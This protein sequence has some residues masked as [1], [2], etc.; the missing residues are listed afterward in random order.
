M[1]L[2]GVAGSFDEDGDFAKRTTNLKHGLGSWIW[3]TNVYPRQTCRFWRTFEV[4]GGSPVVRALL[5]VTADNGYL[6][7]LDGRE[8]GKGSNWKTVAEYD[9][10]WRLEPGRHILAVEA[11]ND[12]DTGGPNIAGVILGLR[13]AFADGRVLELGTDSSWRVPPETERDW[14]KRRQAAPHWPAAT[15]LAPWGGKKEW[16]VPLLIAHEPPV[17]PAAVHFWQQGWFQVTMLSVCGVAVAVCLR[18]MAQMTLQTRA[19]RLLQLERARIARDIHDELGAGLTRLVL[20][21]EVTQSE[22]PPDSPVRAQ[23]SQLCERTR[24]L[25]QVMDEVVWAVN[26]RRDTLQDFATYVCKYAGTFLAPTPIRCRLDVE[27]ELPSVGFDLPM[28]RYL[29]LAVKEALHNAA[30]HSRAGELFVRIHR[31]GEGIKVVIEDDGAGFD[32]ALVD[33]TRNGLGNMTQRLAEVG[34]R[35][36]VYS[37][38]GQGCRVEFE[39]PALR[40]RR[41]PNGLRW[42]VGRL[43]S[44]A[45]RPTAARRAARRGGADGTTRI[46]PRNV[47]DEI[48]RRKP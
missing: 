23:L 19:E 17:R 31:W 36:H 22:Q 30:K 38:P 44:R 25:S 11:F 34:G 13:I 16:R 27:T 29:F 3:T 32:D 40:T 5:R 15:V 26:S 42:W 14:H 35:C 18:L 7:F 6:L 10:V 8:I 1:A 4:P 41:E 39:L 45:P 20:L 43:F 28:R 48:C 33:P 24:E 37:A 12:A 46:A 2:A 47:R 21:G 9:L